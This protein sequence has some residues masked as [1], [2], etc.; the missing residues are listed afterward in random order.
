MSL[1]RV[2]LDTILLRRTKHNKRVK[3]ERAS[4]ASAGIP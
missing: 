2:F 3:D 1:I 4:P